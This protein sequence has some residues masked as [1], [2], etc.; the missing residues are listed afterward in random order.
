MANKLRVGVLASTRGTN[1]QALIDDIN[2]GNDSYEIAC[3][4]SNVYDAGAL[5]KAKRNGIPAVF[6]DPAE[7]T[8]EE[9]DSKMVYVM[10]KYNVE[11]VC[12]IGYMRVLNKVFID[13]YKNRIINVHPSLIPAFCGPGYYGNAVHKAVLEDG[14]K[15][16][17]MT[18]H[19][20]DE[21]VDTGE[22]ICQKCCEIREH[23]DIND[24]RIKVQALEKEWYPK[25]VND[26]AENKK[27]SCL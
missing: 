6:L 18:I 26:F 20:V 14:C 5:E 3:V 25:I 4:V 22:I 24:I 8:K 19:Y 27:T 2:S 12:L 21:G 9:Y 16:T 11:L 7:K 10:Q 13:A 15:V 1:L 17:G 23:E